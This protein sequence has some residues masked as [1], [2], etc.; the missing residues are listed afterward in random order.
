MTDIY[1]AF[2]RRF[3]RRALARLID[4]KYHSLSGF[5]RDIDI[6]EFRVYEW[7][8]SGAKPRVQTLLKI[9]E[10]VSCSI[11]DIAP[12]LTSNAT[13]PPAQQPRQK[14]VYRGGRAAYLQKNRA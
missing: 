2:Q 7:L 12:R 6:Y 13:S 9:C 3:D 14:R 4:K 11:N 1:K 10:V 5:A 8:F